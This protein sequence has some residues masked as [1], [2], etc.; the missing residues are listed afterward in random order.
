[1][2]ATASPP[3]SS[4]KRR[5]PLG[6][7]RQGL[8]CPLRR[9]PRRRGATKGGSTAPC[10]RSRRQPS[11]SCSVSEPHVARG[12][13]ETSGA[14]GLIELY[15]RGIDVPKCRMS[16]EQMATIPM[17]PIG[18]IT[19]LNRSILHTERGMSGTGGND[20]ICG[21]CGYVILEDFDPST[22]R[23]NP[24]YQCRICGNNNDLPFALSDRR[25]SSR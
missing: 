17:I 8:P 25:W 11:S 24:I 6:T 12:K 23:G 20:F 5:S 22:V 16:G 21:H 4:S 3:K 10:K 7:D 18:P 13:S 15:F 14:T 19:T 1:M 9:L 2:I